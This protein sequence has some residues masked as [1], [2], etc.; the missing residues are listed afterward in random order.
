MRVGWGMSGGIGAVDEELKVIGVCMKRNVWV[1]G[2]D[3]EHGEEIN[4]K[5]YR[6]KNSTLGNIMGDRAGEMSVS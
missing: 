5:K 3:L 4:V 6:T 1:V 2:K